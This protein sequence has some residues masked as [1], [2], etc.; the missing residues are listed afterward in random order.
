MMSGS[1]YHISYLQILETERRLKLSS[2][3]NIFPQQSHSSSIQTFIKSFTSPDNINTD[4][5]DDFI[6]LDPFLE[7]IGDLSSIECSTQ[8]LQSLAFIEGYAVHKYLKHYQ[9][10]HVCLDALTFEKEFLFDPDFPS[11]FKLLQLTERGRL[12]YPSEPVFYVVIILWKI[13]VL[14]ESDDKLLTLLVEGSSR[15][16]L[17]QLTL[18]FIREIAD[19]IIWRSNCINCAACRWK[20]VRKLVFTAANCIIANKIKIT[21]HY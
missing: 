1:N 13:F 18:I 12:K 11:E 4:D 6:I 21:T 5:D 9:P 8:V 17:V 20:I 16:I 3:L 2:V 14:I 10:C 15:K 7:D 19:N